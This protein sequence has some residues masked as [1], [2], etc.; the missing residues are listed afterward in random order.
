MKMNPIALLV[1]CPLLVWLGCSSDESTTDTSSSSDASTG[2]TSGGGGDGTAGA[3]ADGGVGGQVG[4]GGLAAGGQAGAG[5]GDGCP[6]VP[7]ED[8]AECPTLALCCEYPAGQCVCAK[9]GAP[10]NV[11]QCGPD[12]CP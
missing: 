11:W 2:A 6:R 9:Q 4:A 1:A 3:G 8:G 12:A 5:G 10:V 7:P